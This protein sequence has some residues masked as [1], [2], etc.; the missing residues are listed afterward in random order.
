MILQLKDE[1]GSLLYSQL[2]EDKK[3]GFYSPYN[4]RVQR[5]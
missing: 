4:G 1:C 5:A 3:L 2:E